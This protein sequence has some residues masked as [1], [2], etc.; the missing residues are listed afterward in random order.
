MARC[1]ATVL[2]AVR[3]TPENSEFHTVQ[4]ATN[5]SVDL[6][7]ALVSIFGSICPPLPY[8]CFSSPTGSQSVCPSLW[9][10]LLLFTVRTLVSRK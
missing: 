7:P 1:E 9:S 6:I 10:N 4:W 3:L 2:T 5:T 8:R